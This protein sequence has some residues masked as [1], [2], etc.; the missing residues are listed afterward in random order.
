MVSSKGTRTSYYRT[1]DTDVVVLAVS[2][3][4]KLECDRLYI[5]FGTGKSFRYLDATY[6]A[7]M[8]GNDRCTALPSFHALTG[9]DITSSFA[10]IRKRTA[11]SAWN[12]FDDMTPALC[13]LAQMPTPADVRQLLPVIE[14]YIVLMYDRGSSDDSVNMA[15]Q[16]LFTQKG[17]DIDNVPPTQDALYQHLL[18]VGYQAGH[19]WGQA[20]LNTPQLP[21]QQILAGSR[22]TVQRVGKWHGW[23][24]CLLGQHAVLWSNVA[25]LKAKEEDVNAQRKICPAHCSASVEAVNERANDKMM[26]YEVYMPLGIP[27][28]FG[29]CEAVSLQSKKTWAIPAARVHINK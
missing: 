21:V 24:S 28:V 16:T 4:H 3:A 1:V 23:T 7:L 8:L 22:K 11:W 15:R 12:A 29:N 25:V 27:V 17:R 14:R 6:M 20:L 9:C 2:L 13:T 19:V 10:G 26:A 5:A 18:R